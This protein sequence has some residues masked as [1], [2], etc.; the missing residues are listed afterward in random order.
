[1]AAK[2]SPKKKPHANLDAQP[3]AD[4]LANLE[5]TVEELSVVIRAL[6]RDSATAAKYMAES[7]LRLRGLERKLALRK[8]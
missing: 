1:M 8:G 2:K 4:R 7:E 6:M 5:A 3:T